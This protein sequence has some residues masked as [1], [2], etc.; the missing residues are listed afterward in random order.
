MSSVDPD[1]TV[2]AGGPLVGEDAAASR[3]GERA[4]IHRGCDDQALQIV[5]GAD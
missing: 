5:D 2:F 1:L 3:G 4:G